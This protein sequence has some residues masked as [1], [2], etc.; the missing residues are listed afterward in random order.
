ME[1]LLGIVLACLAIKLCV[2][3]HRAEHFI[4]AKTDM[5][6]Y[7]LEKEKEFTR[8]AELDGQSVGDYNEF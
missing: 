2:L 5:E 7:K 3:I 4:K 8:L 6:T 1:I